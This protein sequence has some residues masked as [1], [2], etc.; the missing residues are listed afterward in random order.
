MQFA[1]AQY[2]SDYEVHLDFQQFN[3]HKKAKDWERVIM[4][5]EQEAML[6]FTAKA[7]NN[8]V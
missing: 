8:T 3:Q 5:I 7:I 4:D 6:T 2:A 1:I